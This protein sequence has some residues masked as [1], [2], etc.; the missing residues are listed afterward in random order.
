MACSTTLR[1]PEAGKNFKLKLNNLDK[2]IAYIC[3]Q[4][5]LNMNL[6]NIIMFLFINLSS[7]AYAEIYVNQ[8]NSGNIEYSDTPS[9]NAKKV[10]VPSVNSVQGTTDG[11]VTSNSKTKTTGSV[12]SNYADTV[13]K[14]TE[15]PI[16]SVTTYKTFIINTPKSEEVIKDQPVVSV[17]MNV[18]P[19]LIAGD[20]VHLTLD[21]QAVGTPTGTMYQEIQHVNSG[22][23]TLYATIINIQKQEVKKSDIITF[24]VEKNP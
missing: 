18:E 22:T 3:Q 16:S 12:A 15:E 9:G 24:Y 20:T 21:G 19:L 4:G 23:H 2:S 8:N 6:Q 11:A 10:E 14:N 1:F 13:S 7:A 17:E 5:S